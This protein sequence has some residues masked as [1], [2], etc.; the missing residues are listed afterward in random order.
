MLWWMLNSNLLISMK[1]LRFL[2][3]IIIISCIS[4]LSI[5][6]CM[7]QTDA[8]LIKKFVLK[9]KEERSDSIDV[10]I[11]NINMPVLARWNF[12]GC[13]MLIIALDAK[14]DWSEN[15]EFISLTLDGTPNYDQYGKSGT[16][17]HFVEQFMEQINEKY[18][19]GIVLNNYIQ[20]DLIITLE[21]SDGSKVIFDG[22]YKGIEENLDYFCKY[23][24]ILGII[25]TWME[26]FFLGLN[27]W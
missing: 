21:F 8:K 11:L 3:S 17:A 2:I 6:C 24:T 14:G 7:F 25:T 26:C 10:E 1:K 5:S 20:K 9:L 12:C 23:Y 13:E 18:L 4:L 16:K 22:F 27:C 19:N 15:N